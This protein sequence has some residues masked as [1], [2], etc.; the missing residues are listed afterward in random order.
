MGGVALW[1]GPINNKSVK[2]RRCVAESYSNVVCHPA[3]IAGSIISVPSQIGKSLLFI[4][5]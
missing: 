5:R 3:A 2:V 1:Q 4:W